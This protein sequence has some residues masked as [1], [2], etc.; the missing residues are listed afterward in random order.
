MTD[1][2]LRKARELN[3]AK[4]KLEKV[5]DF[6]TNIH[7]HPHFLLKNKL[8][9]R[10]IRFTNT[11]KYLDISFYDLDYKTQIELKKLMREYIENRIKEIEKEYREL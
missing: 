11:E 4:E 8:F 9:K 7:T 10:D 3:T 6:F 1:E 5:Y 2:T